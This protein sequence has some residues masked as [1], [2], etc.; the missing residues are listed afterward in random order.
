MLA[1]LQ[2]LSV[3]GAP[4]E[5]CGLLF[6]TG[7]RV[8]SFILTKNAAENRTLHFEIDPAALITAEREMR[9]GGTQILGYF[10]SHPNGSIQPSKTD[11]A[12]AIP[13]GRFWLILNGEEAS[14]WRSVE[15]GEVCDRFD[16][17]I[18]DCGNVKGQ[19]AAE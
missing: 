11:A 1:Q 3:E 5:I 2:Q 17:I 18:L 14:A 10:H 7:C 12:C 13:D 16:T 9:S 4:E 6:G 19:T 8:D 15:Q